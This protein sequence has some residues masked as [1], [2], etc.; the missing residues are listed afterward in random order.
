MHEMA[1]QDPQRNSPQKESGPDQGIIAEWPLKRHERL[2]VS[3]EYFGGAWLF[4]IRKWFETEGGEWRPTKQGVAVNLK[5]LPGLAEAVTQGLS[6]AH[7][8][9]LIPA[10][11]EGGE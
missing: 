1:Q 7:A 2:R 3:L 10:D 5:H 8:R 11:H 6:T 9:G 4:N